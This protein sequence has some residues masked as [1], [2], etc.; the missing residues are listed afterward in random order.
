[1]VGLESTDSEFSDVTSG[2]EEEEDT[3]S[4]ESEDE[5]EDTPQPSTSRGTP[6]RPNKRQGGESTTTAKRQ[7][8]TVEQRTPSGSGSS[9]LT[10]VS[11]YDPN[12][13]FAKYI[14]S[15]LPLLSPR[16]QVELRHDIQNTIHW[17]LQRQADDR[18]AKRSNESPEVKENESDTGQSKST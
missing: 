6:K 9:S 11:S 14:Q 12:E 7:R 15:E 1:M 17:A 18:A 3:A 2:S 8:R 16:R 10:V 13:S 5:Y 4:A